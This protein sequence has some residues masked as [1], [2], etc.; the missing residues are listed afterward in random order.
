M[1]GLAESFYDNREGWAQFLIIVFIAASQILANILSCLYCEDPAP[2][3][4]DARHLNIQ[5]IGLGSTIFVTS[6]IVFFH[7]LRRNLKHNV[8]IQIPNG[9]S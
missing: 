4:R 7:L 1:L 5:L 9:A 8:L 3:Q 2:F 6:I